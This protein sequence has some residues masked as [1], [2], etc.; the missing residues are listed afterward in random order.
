MG[1]E[2]AP[3]PNS[4]AKGWG[5]CVTCAG[6][7]PATAERAFRERVRGLGGEV[8]EERWLGKDR[9]HRALCPEGHE[10]SPRPSDVRK[11]G[12]LC[13]TCAKM[14]P[15]AAEQAFRE[16]VA[17]LAGEVLEER[18]LGSKRPHR[19]RCVAGH[20][21]L[22][23]PSDVLRGQGVCRFCAGQSWDILYVV[24]RPDLSRV[25]FGITSGDPRARLRVHARSGM[26]DQ[27]RLV[28]N[29]PAASDVEK[30]LIQEL[31]ILGI[32]PVQG[33]ECYG[34]EALPVIL[35]QVDRCAGTDGGT[36]AR[37]PGQSPAGG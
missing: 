26:T 2:C 6:M 37:V 3:R 11:G 10:C 22:P 28:R 1:H 31:K 21:C 9:P 30:Q 25:K 19:V 7:D 33:R 16:R 13:L 34:P 14:D 15:R 17:A 8:V 29:W 32:V 4:V 5:L 24:A 18:W 36:P 27:L 35:A 23:R 20:E 12:G